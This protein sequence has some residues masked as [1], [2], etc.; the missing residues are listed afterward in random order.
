MLR[1]NFLI[2]AVG[3]LAS[4]LALAAP[5][6]Y[7][8][9]L[10]DFDG[11]ADYLARGSDLTGSADGKEGMLSV[12]LRID[13]D[14]GT[15]RYIVAAKDLYFICRLDD[16]NKFRFYGYNAAAA[17]KLS[18]VTTTAY[19]A[20]SSWIHFSASW[21]LAASAGHIYINDSDDLAGGSTLTDDDIDYTR[22]DWNLAALPTGSGLFNGVLAELYFAQEY[23]DFS[24]TANRRLFISAD[25]YPVDLGANG[26]KPT[27]TAPII[28]MRERA[29]NAGINSGTGGDFTINGAPAFTEGPAG[30]YFP[31]TTEIPA[32]GRG[33][34]MHRQELF[35]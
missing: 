4:A 13:G 20:S 16:T 31:L 17:L 32:R 24:V 14:D 5:T 15:A 28:Y 22:P 3:I 8:A 19:T 26:E 25:G 35:Q 29:N 18:I 27:G 10:G 1:R 7:P 2:L 34:R 12:W 6:Y 21:N 23:L 9:A 11:A 30:P 33:S